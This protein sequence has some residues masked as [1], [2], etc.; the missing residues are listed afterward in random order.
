MATIEHCL[1]EE[2]IQGQS[3]AIERLDAE[4]SYKK[5]KL[6]DLKQSNIRMEKKID[7]L[8]DCV[9]QLV[10]ISKTDDE[11]LDKRLTKIETRLDTQEKDAKENNKKNRDDVNIKI[12]IVGVILVIIQIYLNYIR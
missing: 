8:K 6:D 10:L 1:H 7:D 3:R 2:Q 12:A 11:K 9:N 5:E 4:L